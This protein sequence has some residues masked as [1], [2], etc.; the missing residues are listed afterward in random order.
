MISCPSFR[1]SQHRLSI[2]ICVMLC[3]VS[4]RWAQF[5]KADK[6][7]TEEQRAGHVQDL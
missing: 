7:P 1:L 2:P 5:L 4:Y 6:G 3:P